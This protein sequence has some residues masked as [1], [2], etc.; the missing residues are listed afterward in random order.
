M[1]IIIQIPCLNEEENL[2]KVI[3]ELPRKYNEHD[4]DILVIN[5]GSI[6]NTSKAAKARV[7]YINLKESRLR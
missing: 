6:D 7:K 4:I 5:D 1:K 2:P 3:K